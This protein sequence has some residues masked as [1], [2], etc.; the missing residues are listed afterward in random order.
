MP[1]KSIALFVGLALTVTAIVSARRQEAVARR[2]LE[3]VAPVHRERRG[4]RERRRAA[5]RHGPRPADL[6]PLRRHAGA[7]QP[8]VRRRARQRGDV[9]RQGNR[10]IRTGVGH[11]R[12]VGRGDR[13]ADDRHVGLERAVVGDVGEAVRSGVVGVG[14]IDESAVGTQ[15]Q[16]TVCRPGLNRRHRSS[17]SPSRSLASTPGGRHV[18]RRV[19][20]RGVGVVD[21]GRCFVDRRHRHVDVPRRDAALVVA[22]RIRERRRRRSSRPPACR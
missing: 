11:R 13:Q 9:H 6:R 3:H 4:R 17:P 18:Q 21:G 7:R 16:R 8:V 14:R 5:E 12:G 19:L 22:D 10:L 2:Q 15:R 1:P 20:V